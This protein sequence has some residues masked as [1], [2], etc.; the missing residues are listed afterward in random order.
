MGDAHQDALVVK[1]FLRCRG[2]ALTIYEHADMRAASW[3]L[4]GA[5]FAL[6]CVIG[7]DAGARPFDH[8]PHHIELLT[9]TGNSFLRTSI[10][11][12]TS[13]AVD[14]QTGVSPLSPSAVRL[15]LPIGPDDAWGPAVVRLLEGATWIT[16]RRISPASTASRQASQN[17]GG[18]ILASGREPRGS[19]G[20]P[21]G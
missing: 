11:A 19:P 2:S 16:V 20:E 1:C 5:A 6:A 21:D 17:V 7:L 18:S 10:T 14:T 13:G 8:R 3:V 4:P 9:P 15:V 12:A